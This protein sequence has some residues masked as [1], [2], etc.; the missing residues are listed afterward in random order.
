MVTKLK[1]NK[2]RVVILIASPT[3]VRVMVSHANRI[4]LLRTRVWI[5]AELWEGWVHKLSNL[6]SGYIG[7]LFMHPDVPDILD[8][9]LEYVNDTTNLKK[10]CVCVCVCCLLYTSP[11]PRDF[12]RSRMP[13]SA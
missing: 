9:V 11:S 5:V 12:C 8:D 3:N 7:M 13:S 10:V 6:D 2:A 4:R 1:A